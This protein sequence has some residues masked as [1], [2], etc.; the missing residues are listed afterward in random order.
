MPFPIPDVAVDHGYN[1]RTHRH[2]HLTMQMSPLVHTWTACTHRLYVVTT[3]VEP[4]VSTLYLQRCLEAKTNY[5]H[6][7]VRLTSSRSLR[8]D[9]MC[10]R[11][12]TF[13]PHLSSSAYKLIHQNHMSRIRIGPARTG[14]GEM[15]PGSRLAAT[16]F[17]GTTLYCID[18]IADK[19]DAGVALLYT[20]R[21][22]SATVK[23]GKI[24]ATG[25]CRR[26]V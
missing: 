13:F 2:L 22:R 3:Q 5:S 4:E 8:T 7:T 16:A 1:S 6:T 24:V 21:K 10:L 25:V 9:T 26:P 12:A 17:G 23:S 20:E 14:A 18:M 15:V 19:R 11:L